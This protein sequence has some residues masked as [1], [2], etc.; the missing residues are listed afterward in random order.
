MPARIRRTVDVNRTPGLASELMEKSTITTGQRKRDRRKVVAGTSANRQT[1][2]TTRVNSH[3]T[4]STTCHLLSLLCRLR[5]IGTRIAGTHSGL[6]HIKM[7]GMPRYIGSTCQSPVILC[8][9]SI[10]EE[11]PV[12]R[13]VFCPLAFPGGEVARRMDD[14]CFWLKHQA[15]SVALASSSAQP[16]A[17]ALVLMYDGE[18]IVE[19]DSINVASIHAGPAARAC[20]RVDHGVVIGVGDRLLD[21]PFCNAP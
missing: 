11:L 4:I 10:A 8:I 19:G 18:V 17:D 16:T 21:S 3:D 14:L 13:T 2:M 9:L 7:R 15:Y 1:A 6:P 5:V 20:I 12:V